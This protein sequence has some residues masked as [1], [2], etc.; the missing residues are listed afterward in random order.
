MSFAAGFAVLL[1][2]LLAV[3]VFLVVAVS[4]GHVTLKRQKLNELAEAA[5]MHMNGRGQVPRFIERL[6]ERIDERVSAR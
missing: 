4:S 3:A 2:I 5:E 1:V 6:E